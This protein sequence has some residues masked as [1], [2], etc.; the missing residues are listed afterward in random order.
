MRQKKSIGLQLKSGKTVI[1]EHLD[2]H[3]Y[4]YC[5]VLDVSLEYNYQMSPSLWYS[6]EH[7]AASLVCFVSTASKN[8]Q[9]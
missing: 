4:C 8:N 1:E 2:I 9:E 6:S 3:S 5:I 7:Y